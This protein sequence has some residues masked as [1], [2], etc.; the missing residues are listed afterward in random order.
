MPGKIYFPSAVLTSPLKAQNMTNGGGLTKAFALLL[1]I[2]ES[3]VKYDIFLIY[4]LF[5]Y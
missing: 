3:L 4:F 1:Y 2:Q 5:K